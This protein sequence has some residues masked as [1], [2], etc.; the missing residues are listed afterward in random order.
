MNRITKI[1][2]LYLLATVISRHYFRTIYLT[3]EI[4]QSGPNRWTISA[5]RTAIQSN[6][7]DEERQFKS[8]EE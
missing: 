5:C 8:E 3:A 2:K 6:K 7:I 1:S 4:F